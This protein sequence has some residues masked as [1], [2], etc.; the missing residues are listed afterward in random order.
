MW[1][2]PKVAFPK[3]STLA[4]PVDPGTEAHGAGQ[5][6][7]SGHSSVLTQAHV[8]T[9]PTPGE[10]SPRGKG[11]FWATGCWKTDLITCCLP[12]P[13]ADKYCPL[14]IKEGGLPLLRDMIKMA[15]AR[16]ETKEMA[17]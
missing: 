1:L 10:G 7:G 15:T 17:R 16:Q 12:L 6:G 14:L 5:T 2:C 11:G 9:P 13:A 8:S 4:P 3:D